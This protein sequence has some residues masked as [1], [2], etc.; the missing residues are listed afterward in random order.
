MNRSLLTTLLSIFMLGGTIFTGVYYLSTIVK[1]PALA[2]LLG[3]VPIS[4][5]CIYILTNK[6]IAQCYVRNIM[7]I[8]FLTI[9]VF[10]ILLFLFP[11]FSPLIA[12]TIALFLWVLLQAGKYYYFDQ[13]YPQFQKLK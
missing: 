4:L 2:A 1:N 11:Y 13:H 6:K 9:I 7:V 3:A 8:L 5:L 12:V 10:G